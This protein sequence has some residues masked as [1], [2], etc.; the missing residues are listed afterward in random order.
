MR[1]I[2]PHFEL[3]LLVNLGDI[4]TEIQKEPFC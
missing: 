2:D 4:Q 3:S 1:D